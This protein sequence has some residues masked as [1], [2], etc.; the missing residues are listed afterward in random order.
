MKS[1]WAVLRAVFRG[2]LRA[3]SDE[4]PEMKRPKKKAGKKKGARKAAPAKEQ[5]PAGPPPD[6]L[7]WWVTPEMEP[8][9]APETVPAAAPTADP[10]PAPAATKARVSVTPASGFRT[11]ATPPTRLPT[12]KVETEDGTFITSASFSGEHVLGVRRVEKP[13]QAG[14]SRRHRRRPGAPVDVLAAEVAPLRHCEV[15]GSAACTDMPTM[16]EPK[17]QEPEALPFGFTWCDPAETEA[18]EGEAPEI[19][20]QGTESEAVDVDA[21]EI[22]EERE[23]AESETENVP[24]GDEVDDHE[25]DVEENPSLESAA[26]T[27]PVTPRRAPLSKAERRAQR[28]ARKQRAAR[29]ARATLHAR[30]DA[31]CAPGLAA[32]VNSAPQGDRLRLVTSLATRVSLQAQ[33]STDQKGKVA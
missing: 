32:P 1:V 22:V 23:A 19:D 11:D 4:M 14:E 33:P 15:A 13:R 21:E 24:E 25:V 3:F 10:A 2:V 9:P 31:S 26:T 20:D 29:Q 30:T 28:K 6:E 8:Q 16:P 18:V 12:I 27:S 17:A 5:A 7:L